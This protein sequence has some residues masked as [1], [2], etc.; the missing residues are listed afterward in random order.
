MSGLRFE[1]HASDVLLLS[2]PPHMGLHDH[3]LYFLAKLYGAAEKY[4]VEE[5][6]TRKDRAIAEYQGAAGDQ[7]G[8]RVEDH[9]ALSKVLH[10]LF[11]A[12]LAIILGLAV[13]VMFWSRRSASMKN[14]AIFHVGFCLHHRL[15]R[16][17]LSDSSPPK[18]LNPSPLETDKAMSEPGASSIR[19]IFC[20]SR[21]N[22]RSPAT[23]VAR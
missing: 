11:R 15:F 4:P 6:A 21:G 1:C 18:A 3:R 7:R 12:S 10:E 14:R 22:R 20:W 5:E 9:S 13:M 19:K 17:R 23:T 16:R 8:G 2:F